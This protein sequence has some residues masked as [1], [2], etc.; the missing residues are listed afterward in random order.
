M[1]TM[2]HAAGVSLDRVL[3]ELNL[4][5]PRLVTGVHARYLAAGADIVLTNTFRASRPQLALAGLGDRAG[6]IN[7]AGANLAREAVAAAGGEAF[8][9]GSIGPVFTGHQR[10]RMPV[11]ARVEALLE[12]A[13][14][15][16]ESG[17]DLLHFETFADLTELMAA[18]QACAAFGLP[19]VGQLTFME[20]ERTLMGQEPE[21]VAAAL[22]E[23][24]LTVVGTN[25]TLGPQ[26]ILRVL[27]RLGERTTLPLSAQ[28]NAGLPRRVGR[29]RFEYAVRDDYFARHGRM[30]AEL[31]A[32]IVGGCCGTTPEHINAIHRAVAGLRP[33]RPPRSGT[34]R[35]VPGLAA[36]PS[37]SGSTLRELLTGE[38]FVVGVEIRPPAGADPNP[39]VE[40]ALECCRS[41]AR[42]ISVAPASTARAQ[43][44]ALSLA[45]VLKLQTPHEVAVTVTTW[46][47]SIISLQADLLGAQACGVSTVICRTGNPPLQ[48]D[49]PNLD[50]VW[51]VDSIGLIELLRSLNEGIDANGIPIRTPSSFFIGARFNP[52]AAD[53]DAEISRTRAKMSAGADFLVTWPLYDSG[54]LRRMHRE[55]GEAAPPVLL[56]L[57]PLR[58]ASEAD[59]LR[60]EVP[61][62][63]VPEEVAHRL[64]GAAGDDRNT[65]LQVALEVLADVQDL[66]QGVVLVRRDEPEQIWSWF[67]SQARRTRETRDHLGIKGRNG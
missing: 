40:Q 12:Q 36:V 44:S 38:R 24:G 10:S 66:V 22:Q 59:F 9:A 58:D 45:S 62:V 43:M 37:P 49:Y 8:V 35:S 64:T 53:L 34:G 55:L 1:G 26:G 48:G 11:A 41:G 47:R 6:E 39:S 31:G 50:G 29:R 3:P 57:Q 32:S 14:F 23:S 16:A 21:A 15:L 54:R 63:H 18:V 27:R 13:T 5:D 61:D 46:D 33:L 4:T 25:C 52:G 56:T 17:A 42:F 67:L 30:Y 2:L 19:I 51:D 20:D 7:H 65:G 60:H 28:P